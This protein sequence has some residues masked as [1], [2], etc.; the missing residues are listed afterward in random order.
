MRGKEI[1]AFHHQQ[2]TEVYPGRAVLNET[3][4]Y[5]FGP[6]IE[7]LQEN[8]CPSFAGYHAWLDIHEGRR[9]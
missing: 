8:L 7:P 3:T 9:A 4:H 2:G 6:K 5:S 1:V